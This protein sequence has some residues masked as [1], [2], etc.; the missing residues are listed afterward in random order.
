MPPPAADRLTDAGYGYE[1]FGRTTTTTP[2]G[3]SLT[4]HLNDLISP[5]QTAT[6]RTET[7]IN[8]A[9]ANATSKL[10]HYGDDSDEVRWVAE[11]TTLGS[12]TRNVSGPDG[13]LVASTSATGDVRLRLASLH[14]NVVITT[15]TA[16]TDPDAY[17]LRRVRRTG[18]PGRGR[19]AVRVAGRDAALRRNH[20]RHRPDGR[21]A[22]QPG[23][24]PV[25]VGRP[26]AGRISHR[27]RLLHARS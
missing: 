24:R 1:A 27:L 7:W 16:L 14:G 11:D 19:A 21:P 2:D 9:W 17:D 6:D 12:V 4:Y 22:V 15:D 3:M 18:Q 10:N 8:G 25:P 23:A 26:R 13:G 5:Q 20:R